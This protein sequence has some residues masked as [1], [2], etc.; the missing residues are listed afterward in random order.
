MYIHLIHKFIAVKHVNEPPRIP[1]HELYSHCKKEMLL[2]QYM[3]ITW[4]PEHLS[5]LRMS[6]G[7]SFPPLIT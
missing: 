5:S 4:F 1:F 6:N 7:E 2:V 3:S